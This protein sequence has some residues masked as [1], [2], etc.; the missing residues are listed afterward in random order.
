MFKVMMQSTELK[1][2]SVLLWQFLITYIFSV[3]LTFWACYITGQW[4]EF[5]V[6]I[7]ILFLAFFYCFHQKNCVLI[8]FFFWW[9]IKILQQNINHLENGTGNKKLSVELCV[10]FQDRWPGASFGSYWCNSLVKFVT[11]GIKFRFTCGKTDLY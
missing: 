10:C 8:K 4:G 5:R 7:H 6:T 9:S 2:W 11:L 1:Y 3:S